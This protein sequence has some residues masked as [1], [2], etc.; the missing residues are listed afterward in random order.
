MCIQG[1][2]SIGQTGQTGSIFGVIAKRVASNWIDRTNRQHLD[3]DGKK[4]AHEQCPSS[5]L[6]LP[7]SV[8]ASRFHSFL[9]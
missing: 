6:F 5:C 2:A 1:S 9:A 4:H 3:C 8:P 7:V